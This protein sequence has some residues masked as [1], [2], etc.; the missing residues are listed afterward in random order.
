MKGELSL[1]ERILRYLHNKWLD[2]KDEWISGMDVEREALIAGKKSSSADTRMRELVREGLIEGNSTKGYVEYR[3][4]DPDSEYA[5][6]LVKKA[7]ENKKLSKSKFEELKRYLE[8][9]DKCNLEL[10]G[11]SYCKSCGIEGKDI[12]GK[13]REIMQYV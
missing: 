13:I 4:L 9:I 2:D 11:M 5:K 7:E 12:L 8:D 6:S 1:K 3:Y 10:H